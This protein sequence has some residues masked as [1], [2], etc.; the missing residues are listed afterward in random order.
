MI[1]RQRTGE[2]AMVSHVTRATPPRGFR[3]A[4]DHKATRL[5]E[6]LI[7]PNRALG[8][9]SRVVP[10]SVPDRRLPP[11]VTL[12]FLGDGCVVHGKVIRDNE[13]KVGAILVSAL[14]ILTY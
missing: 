1:Q 10:R 9:G 3:C 8:G 12:L 7:A 14:S 2:M 5:S 4:G 11:F 6:S 13:L